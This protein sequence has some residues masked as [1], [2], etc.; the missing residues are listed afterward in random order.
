MKFSIMTIGIDNFKNDS[1]I[2]F[3]DGLY[4]LA[5]QWV[6]LPT[7]KAYPIFPSMMAF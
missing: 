4:L 2:T 7:N 3:T 5:H 1:K 6:F